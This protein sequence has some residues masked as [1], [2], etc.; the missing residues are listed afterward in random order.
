[1]AVGD[2]HAA[3]FTRWGSGTEAVVSNFD[4]RELERL[5]SA[6]NVADVAPMTLEDIF[7]AVTG[8]EGRP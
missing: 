7:I 3:S 6:T 2:L 1:M 8:E 5:R 4:E